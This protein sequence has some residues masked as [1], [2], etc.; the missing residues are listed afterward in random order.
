MRAPFE[1]GEIFRAFGT[2]Y[3]EA[4]GEAMPLRQHRAMRAIEACRT[5]EL[6]GHVEECDACAHVRI[7]YNSCRN[8]HCPKCQFL[9]KERWLEK[10]KQDLL[11]IRYFHVVFTLPESLRPIALRN[12]KALYTLLFKAASETLGELA[13]DPKYLGAEIGFTALLHTW[14]RTLLHHPHLHCIVT[15][16]GLSADG[17]RWKKARRRFFLP[18]RVLS[19]L[20][21]GKFLSL[22]KRA[23]RSGG[24]VF[25]GA[26]AA[27]ENEASFKRFLRGLYAEQWVVYCKPPFGNAAKV[28]KYL[29]RYTHRVAL[30]N[31]R[32]V[33]MDAGA[34]TFCYRDSADHNLMKPMT[35]DA[36]E[37]IRRFLLHILPDRFMK[38][39]H[40]GLLCNRHR[41]AKLARCKEL[42]AVKDDE[43]GKAETGETWQ[44]LLLRITGID[45]SVC[46]VCGKGKM[47]ALAR[48]PPVCSRGPP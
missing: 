23:C 5:A 24:M 3:R 31:E 11:P 28:L 15:G 26:I 38:I 40:Y 39:R 43:P 16:G 17:K 18:V 34:V 13:R 14:T 35:V 44:A 9:D 29:G 1:V 47:I 46:P 8:R 21:R 30:S 42:L 10:R 48:L 41:A 12:P 2:K 4:H 33:G 36:F 19:K 27:L 7:S 20:F 22:F 37:F 25:C 45:L 32:I 6:G